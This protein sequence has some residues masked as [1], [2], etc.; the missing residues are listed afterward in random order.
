[1]LAPEQTAALQAQVEER[2]WVA[3][4]SVALRLLSSQPNS[5]ADTDAAVGEGGASSSA[6]KEGQKPQSAVS[7]LA[8]TSS[9]G[10]LLAAFCRYALLK[11]LS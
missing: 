6:V 3:A 1:M 11:M 2:M 10:D 8:L 9:A 4:D 7:G 5:N